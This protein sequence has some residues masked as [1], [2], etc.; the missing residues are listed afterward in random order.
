[1]AAEFDGNE[2]ISNEKDPLKFNKLLKN[3]SEDNPQ[4]MLPK[5]RAR[6]LGMMI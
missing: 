6:Q 4:E 2:L 1:M 3:F 5:S